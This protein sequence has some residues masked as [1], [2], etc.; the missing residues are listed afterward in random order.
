MGD[1][2]FE[3]QPLVDP[4]GQIRLIEVLAQAPDMPLQ[5]PLTVHQIA[6]N[7]DFYAISYT[8]GNC[9]FTKKIMI[10]GQPIMVTKN[11][12]Y[13]LKQVNERYPSR[14]G[15]PTYIWIDSICINQ[16]DNDE[17]SYQVAMMGNLYTKASKVLACVGP[18]QDNSQMIRSTLDNVMT[19]S[20]DLY[21]RRAEFPYDDQTT[22]QFIGDHA[23]QMLV[24]RVDEFLQRTFQCAMPE[25][26]VYGLLPLIEWPNGIAPVRPKLYVGSRVGAYLCS[27]AQTGDKLL[28][29]SFLQHL[30]VVR[31][32]SEE[33]E[34][35]IVG[36]G[37]LNF[38]HLGVGRTQKGL[39][40][41]FD[42]NINQAK[43]DEE[44]DFDRLLEL[45]AKP[46]ELMVLYGQDWGRNSSHI[47]AMELDA[48]QLAPK[49]DLILLVN[50]PKTFKVFTMKFQIVL[51]SHLL[52]QSAQAS[53]L[54]KDV[55]GAL[56]TR[57][58]LKKSN[59]SE[60]DWSECDLDFGS[61]YTN[62]QQKEFD[63]ARLSVPLD[64][65]S[66]SSSEKIK[67]DLI[68]AKAWKKPYLGSV[69]Y[70][71]GG[72]G[73]SGVEAVL[74]MGNKLAQVLGGQ[75]DV[76][77]FDP[78]GTGR[79]I[80]FICNGT[81][82][83]GP[84][85]FTNTK[86]LRSR[87]FNSIPQADTWEFVRDEIWDLAGSLAKNCYESQKN[88]GRFIGT[89]F[90][91]RD[92]M[93]IVDALGQGRMLNYWGT[94]YGTILGQVTAS[95]F[96]DRIG[97]MLIDGNLKADDYATTTWITSMRDAERSLTNLFDEC[98]EAGKENCSLADYHGN[99]TTGESL[100]TE[101]SETLDGYLNGTIHADVD[102]DELP[103][104]DMNLLVVT[105]KTLVLGELYSPATYPNIIER[106]EGLFNNNMTAMFK[107]GFSQPG[108]DAWNAAITFNTN[109][110][111]CSDSSF[112]VKDRD[113]LFS[114][115]QAHR[116]EGSFSDIGTIARLFCAQWKFS[117][118]EQ[119]NL[120]KLRT[121]ETKNPL[122]IVNGR[123]DPVTPLS[124]AWGVSSQFPGSR[125]VVHEGVGH[126]LISHPSNCTEEIV[127]NY[128]VDGEMPK[129]NTTCKP[130]M[131]VF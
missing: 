109:G 95:M 48:K 93:A 10:K 125:V 62:K 64:Y 57:D 86:G 99:K 15:E 21:S 66:Q 40:N 76:I 47:R 38:S 16:N 127:K 25:D 124:S 45:K 75:Y 17:K 73:G 8:W 31:H 113:D 30:L 112:R 105:Y 111:A 24:A 115:Y 70:N 4:A 83:T 79:T 50:V 56:N 104:N 123:Y 46:I 11:C 34:F 63:C 13:A 129:I 51:L 36:Q 81:G 100:L 120:N 78:R 55:R 118:K 12:C 42:G 59:S 39:R 61:N 29:V 84:G 88:T 71:P 60:L 37:L 20:S 98:V 87:E 130:D 68:K 77:G 9:G 49:A 91:A 54:P 53:S 90:V 33:G 108:E 96:P 116:A 106:V 74:I 119:I 23:N 89:P 110:I 44:D 122:L 107:I 19:L 43:E 67:L 69:L 41:S 7:L 102:A 26:K 3:H 121:V 82:P 32:S 27:G 103:G 131:P 92:M 22:V 101:F 97:R 18:Q 2:A 72:P 35:D 14:S 126:G 6:Q 65:T 28:H 58:D 94:S 117:A 5:L 128:F 85:N 52:L 1:S 80:P 114:I